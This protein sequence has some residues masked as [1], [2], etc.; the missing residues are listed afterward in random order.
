MSYSWTHPSVIA[1][2]GREDPI[3]VI[4]EKA[5]E[6]VYRAIEGGLAK[7]VDPF[8]LA[9]VRG[10][11]LLP[12]DDVDDARTVP[13]GS[14]AF[15]IEYNPN[16][17]RDRIRFSIAHELAHTLF[18]DADLRVRHRV[19]ESE[20]DDWQLEML[21]N[22]A[23]AE[24]L[25]P[26]GSF[27]NLVDEAPSIERLLSERERYQVSTEAVLLRVAKLS[28]NPVAAFAASRKDGRMRIDYIVSRGWH[29]PIPTG[30]LLDK[31]VLFDC[32][33]VG[34]TAKK[35]RKVV[36]ESWQD[37]RRMRRNTSLS[38]FYVS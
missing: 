13:V 5:R 12:R 33:A 18:P 26:I 34:F 27:G 22:I 15:R 10:V 28:S 36:S 6:L 3:E 25:M 7:T 38:R 19:D 9:A 31:T 29:P 1:L 4:S 24:L 32:S 8:T 37:A 30:L 11:P 16:R 21:C 14:R 2:A 23:A 17:P 20:G 35:T